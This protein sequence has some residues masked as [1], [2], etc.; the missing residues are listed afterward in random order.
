MQ[1]R[2][3]GG[4]GLAGVRGTES[5]A[6]WAWHRRVLEAGSAFL[7]MQMRL[8]M[9]NFRARER[10]KREPTYT[11]KRQQDNGVSYFIRG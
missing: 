7:H 4:G 1:R 10:E 6:G 2:W 11:G 8:R 3:D 5:F 9:V